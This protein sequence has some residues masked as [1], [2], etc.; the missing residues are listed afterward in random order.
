MKKLI[1]LFFIA[2]FTVSCTNNNVPDTEGNNN[3]TLQLRSALQ[4]KV[5]Q[6]NSF[7]FGLLSETISNNPNN[8]NVFI[9]P[10]SVSIALGMLW[11]GAQGDTRTEIGNTL[12]M[13]GFNT[14]EINEYYRTLQKGLPGLDPK[15][16]L[17]I[18]NAIWYKD[19]FNVL[20]S[21]VNINHENFDAKIKALDF[22]KGWALDTINNWCS[23]STKGLIPKILDKIPQE[24]VMYL[25]NAVY[26]KGVWKTKFDKDL[27][28]LS[29]F[30]NADDQNVDVNMMVLLD[31]FAY[32]SDKLAQYVDM[33]YGNGNYSMTLVVPVSGVTPQQIINQLTGE[34]WDNI[35][36]SLVDAKV[37]IRLPRFKVENDLTLN[38]PL[39]NMGMKAAFTDFADFRGITPNEKIAVSEVKHKTYITVDEDGTEAAAVTSIGMVTTSLPVI[40]YYIVNAD[41]PFFFVIREKSTGIIVFAGKVG[42]PAKF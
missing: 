37:Q 8:K 36:S 32:C 35:I 13:S 14:D 41:R 21:F 19:D 31:T 33:P 22:N 28:T 26:F 12:K 38:E 11:N 5:A 3:T 15:T 16:Q 2:F 25:M 4:K 18:A 27:T 34:K 1:S 6:D 9:S 40:D 24:A 29:S 17:S 42:S 7:S 10:L 20:E 23:K 30:K 39:K